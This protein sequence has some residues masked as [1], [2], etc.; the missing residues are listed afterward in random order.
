MTEEEEA[1]IQMATMLATRVEGPTEIAV[2][3]RAATQAV[4]AMKKHLHSPLADRIAGEHRSW[5]WLLDQL[6]SIHPN[7]SGYYSLNQEEDCPFCVYVGKLR[8]AF[9]EVERLAREHNGG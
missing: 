5:S 7:D 6:T 3:K 1:I 8:N 4:E 9:E 2:A